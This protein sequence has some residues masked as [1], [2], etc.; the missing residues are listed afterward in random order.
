[1]NFLKKSS[2]GISR[3]KGK[4][5]SALEYLIT[6]GWA[7]LIIAVVVSLLYFFVAVPSSVVPNSCSFTSGVDCQD[8]EFGSNSINSSVSILLNN[9]EDYA[10]KDPKLTVNYSN[11][12]YTSSC[13]PNYVLPGGSIVCIVKGL[14][15]SPINNYVHGSLYLNS[16]DCSLAQNSTSCANAPKQLDLGTFAAHTA[17]VVKPNV[18]IKLTAESQSPD[19]N[20]NWPDNGSSD[21]LVANVSFLGYPLSGSTVNFSVVSSS[22][23]TPTISP[24]YS[25][26]NS[27]GVAISYIS[28]TG[29]SKVI[30]NA[31]FG[32][33]TSNQVTVN[34][35]KVTGLMIYFNTKNMT[36]LVRINNAPIAKNGTDVLTTCY[37]KIPYNVTQHKSISNYVY[38]NFSYI[39]FDGVKYTSDSGLLYVNCNDPN[40]NVDVNYTYFYKLTTKTNPTNGGSV[41]PSSNFYKENSFVTLGESND[42]SWSFSNWTCSDPDT[43]FGGNYC[44]SGKN[45]TQVIDITNP[46]NETANF[47]PTLY[48]NVSPGGDGTAIVSSGLTTGST[49]SSSPKGFDETYGSK[50]DITETNNTGYKFVSWTGSGDGSYTGSNQ[51]AT[52]T[53]D[54]VI[55]ETANYDVYLTELSSPSGAASSLSP[56]SG[57]YAP[58]T[59]ITLS[60]S[61]N[62]GYKFEDWTGYQKSTS[63]SFTMTVPNQDFSETAN[64]DVHLTELSSPSGAASSL[65]PGTGWYAPG[66]SITISE[67]NNTG[68]KFMNWTGYQNSS[69]SSFSMTVPTS[70]F[71]ETANYNVY[72][73]ENAYPSAGASSLSP[74]S[75]WYVPGNS[76]TLS[77]SN[78]TGYK[79]VNWTGY[80][81]S[82]SSSFSMTVPTSPFT[83][84]A[85]YDV[86]LTELSSPSG[87]ASSLSPG[88]G[89]YFPG[90]SITLSESNNTGYKFVNWTGYQGS[91][92]SS[93]SMTVPNQDF[94]ETA[95][96]DVRL[97][98]LSSPSGGASSLSPGTGWY[99][100]G[101]SI[102]LSESNNTGYKFEDW[103]GSD[104]SSSSSFSM[105]VPTSPFTET[106]NYDV[107]LTELE[108]PS[109]AASSLSPGSGWYAPGSSITLSESNNTGYKFVD[110]T[111]SDSSSS[112]PFTM[113]VPTSPFTETANYDVY[114]TELSY[115]SI[116]A[117]SLNPGTGW[118]APGNSIKFSESSKEVNFGGYKFMNWTGYQNSSSSSFTMT[119]PN[120]DFSETVNYE[121]NDYFYP[122]QG[123]NNRPTKATLNVTGYYDGVES[124]GTNVVTSSPGTEELN[125]SPGDTIIITEN[126]HIYSDGCSP[127]YGNVFT[128]YSYNHSI[129]Y[130]RESGTVLIITQ[131][132]E[133]TYVTAHFQCEFFA[134]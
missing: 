96:Y 119:V 28:D 72:L 5:Q 86:Y 24:K 101:T 70:P 129:G 10:I 106:A 56:G 76:I 37:T 128:G 123:N 27:K 122:Q 60:E 32:N 118:Y 42:S 55:Y 124:L 53:M 26:T 75:G 31:S 62:T 108:S 132:N 127:G 103:T 125:F 15:Y 68:Y 69:S 41:S 44:Y 80:Q 67:S 81:K 84:T 51:S 52:V 74:G 64:Y 20:N 134:T 6:Y 107:H 2:K 88:S 117:S 94:S 48:M 110:W 115:P 87:G 91:S 13:Y 21:E 47:D 93:F 4:G 50:V 66:T 85:N 111:G 16:S 105:T 9:K 17:L 77:E 19:Y 58:G 83:E 97:T 12:N 102:T 121:V 120:Q 63:S 109:G 79:F 14:K 54:G 100:P 89:W 40:R 33:Y 126:P 61:N 29:L 113:T 34:F 99:A 92:S 130:T 104:S 71:T 131:P 8:M 116:A 59:S 65:S 57:W 90:S 95:N 18:S 25:S 49:S 35:T 82:S 78:N 73:T 38:E 11:V 7:I 133:P 36:D 22:N 3:K 114:L 39:E 98:E 46:M 30:V 43:G 23:T 112:E 1:M 45:S